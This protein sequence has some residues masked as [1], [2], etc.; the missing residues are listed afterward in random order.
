MDVGTVG[1][2]A[3]IHAIRVIRGEHPGDSLEPPAPFAY[4]GIVPLARV[5]GPLGE[6]AAHDE[7]GT[8]PRRAVQARGGNRVRWPP[9][10]C[11]TISRRNSMTWK[12][13]SSEG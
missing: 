8:S 13:P 7:S 12:K 4:D 1:A 3:C 11:L 2:A 6:D 10:S 9:I 5:P